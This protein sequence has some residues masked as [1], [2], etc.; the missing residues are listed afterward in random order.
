MINEILSLTYVGYLTIYWYYSLIWFIKFG[1]NDLLYQY[2]KVA[3][4]SL[5]VQASVLPV[6]G[7]LFSR[8]YPSIVN[9]E[10]ALSG[11][12]FNLHELNQLFLMLIW[13]DVSFWC[14]H[15]ILHLPKFYRWHKLHHKLIHPVPWGAIYA[16]YTE[17]IM[18]NFFPVF[19][20]PLLVKL[21]LCY[22]PVW[23]IISVISSLVSHSGITEHDVHHKTF[24]Y[25]YGP[26]GVIDRIVGT[27]MGMTEYKKKSL[28][29]RYI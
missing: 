26:I 11:P 10:Y 3:I 16:T 21:K 29:T 14:I 6:L 25:N 15:K 24:V 27:H 23:I 12:E 4:H 17:N 2:K 8:L 18:L 28:Y 13:E 20:A 5:K 22:I 1:K 19:V 7:F 9:I